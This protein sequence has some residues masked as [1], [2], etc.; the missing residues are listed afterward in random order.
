MYEK[1]V[2]QAELELITE[3]E[4]KIKSSIKAKVKKRQQLLEDLDEVN[5]EIDQLVKEGK[6]TDLS[7]YIKIGDGFTT[8]STSCISINKN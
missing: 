4:E 1:F 6:I 8:G 3:K 5:K 7:S 2:S